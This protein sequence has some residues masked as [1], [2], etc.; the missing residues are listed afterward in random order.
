MKK[1]LV[2]LFSF[3]FLF[4]LYQLTSILMY[5]H[6]INEGSAL[7][8]NQ[9]LKVNPIII[10]RKNAYT[11]SMQALKDNDTKT[12][13]KETDAYLTASSKY[14][15]EQEIWLKAQRQY[16]DRWDFQY[17]NPSY[18]KEAAMT[19]FVSRVAD[20]RSTKLIVEAF[21]VKDLNMSI[22]EEDGKKAIDQIK[23]RNAADKK[24]DEI[25]DNPGKLD[26]RTQFI[27]VPVSKCPD[28]NFNFPN[29]DEI[30]NPYMKPADSDAPIT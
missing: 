29:V 7:V 9:C 10:E 11:K 18:V 13:E 19:Q 17:F 12:Y 23:I 22:A 28:E 25:W 21:Y 16:V 20:V 2:V 30:L 4:G 1:V 24:Y 14:I 15:K 8:D 3:L 26:W 5:Q 6:L 27:K